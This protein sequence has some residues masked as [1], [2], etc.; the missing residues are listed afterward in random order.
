[1]NRVIVILAALLSVAA[2]AGCGADKDAATT[3]PLGMKATPTLTTSQVADLNQRRR[4]R[5][6][7][8]KAE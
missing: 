2:I 5:N 6:A 7:M 8:R 4:A 3:G 1:M